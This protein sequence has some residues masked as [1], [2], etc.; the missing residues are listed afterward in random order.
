MNEGP[1]LDKW[2]KFQHRLLNGKLTGSPWRVKSLVS[3]SARMSKAN[4]ENRLVHRN[5]QSCSFNL[6]T[7][8]S[9]P[10]SSP[11]HPSRKTCGLFSA[12]PNSELSLWHHQG[13]GQGPLP[14]A[15]L[16]PALVN[17]VLLEHSHPYLF[18]CLSL[19]PTTWE[20]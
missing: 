5:P 18:Y 4:P 11:S 17:K 7:N 2:K 9:S 13:H 8:N 19:L 15:G 16:L 6:W 3:T 10:N 20:N 14:G 1:C 12:E